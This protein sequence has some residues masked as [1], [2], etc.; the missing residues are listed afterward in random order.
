MKA[1][2][3]ARSVPPARRPAADGVLDESDSRAAT[4]ELMR[5]LRDAPGTAAAAF[6]PVRLD[7]LVDG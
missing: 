7:R 4:D 6:M 5:A 2:R 3:V 1:I